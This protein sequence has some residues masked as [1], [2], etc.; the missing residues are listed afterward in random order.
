MRASYPGP[1]RLD[2]PLLTVDTSKAQDITTHA[3]TINTVLDTDAE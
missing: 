2:G 3:T 1:L